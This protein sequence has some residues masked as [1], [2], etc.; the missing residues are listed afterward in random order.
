MWLKEIDVVTAVHSNSVGIY[1]PPPPPPVPA[2]PV[3]K[4]KTRPC[5]QHFPCNSSLYVP[6]SSFSMEVFFFFFWNIWQ[7]STHSSSSGLHNPVP[8]LTLP[9]TS[10]TVIPQC[11]AHGA[12]LERDDDG[13]G[14]CTRSDHT[15]GERCQSF[16]GE[17]FH[18]N[19]PPGVRGRCVCVL[20]VCVW[21]CVGSALAQL[22]VS[23]RFLLLNVFSFFFALVRDAWRL[24][25][26]P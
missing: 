13:G 6:N 25:S 8:G 23:S 14:R 3:I 7:N 1:A 5:L 10:S 2:P 11:R 9:G 15:A 19:L 21:V 17:R 22:F 16:N 20:A 26:I 4:V 24:L 18:L 12:S